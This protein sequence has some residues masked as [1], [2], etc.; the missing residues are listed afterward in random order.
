M[1]ESCSK[2]KYYRE[3]FIYLF[4]TSIGLVLKKYDTCHLKASRWEKKSRMSL[5][6][7]GSVSFPKSIEVFCGGLSYKAVLML[8]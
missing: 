6:R 8:I 7:I 2:E 4:F 1:S 5:I 3:L